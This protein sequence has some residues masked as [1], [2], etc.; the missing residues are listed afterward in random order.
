MKHAITLASEGRVLLDDP[1]PARSPTMLP[2]ALGA[3]QQRY[4]APAWL[5]LCGTKHHHHHIG[6]PGG[7]GHLHC[8]PNSQGTIK[9]MEGVFCAQAASTALLPR[10]TRL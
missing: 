2:K 9:P 5:S 3:V 7:P 10:G 6:F 4:N 1:E 8:V